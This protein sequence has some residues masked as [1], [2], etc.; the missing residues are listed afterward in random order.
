MANLTEE[1]CQKSGKKYGV[2]C[3]PSRSTF[4]ASLLKNSW[5]AISWWKDIYKDIYDARTEDAWPPDASYVR[6]SGWATTWKW[7]GFLSKNHLQLLVR[8]QSTRTPRSIASRQNY[9]LVRFMGRRRPYF[10]RHDQDRH[11]TVIGNRYRSMITEY[12]WPQLDDMDLEDMWFQQNGATSH[13]ENVTINL[14]EN[15]F[16]AASV[17]WFDVVRLF[18]VG[19]RQVYGLCQRISNIWTLFAVLL[20]PRIC[21]WIPLVNCRKHGIED[22]SQEFGQQKAWILLSN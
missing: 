9:G 5:L 10:F 7:F 18:P 3:C 19:L 1:K 13:T 20:I 6:E 14:L 12:F 15:V 22:Y 16:S 8:Q 4:V 17:V 2:I 21:F 11:V